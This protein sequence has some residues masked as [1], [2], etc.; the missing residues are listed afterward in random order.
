MPFIV[1]IVV[2]LFFSCTLDAS[3]IVWS[4]AG[5]MYSPGRIIFHQFERGISL[6]II[7]ALE[8]KIREKN[9]LVSMVTINNAGSYMIQDEKAHRINTLNADLLIEI[10]CYQEPISPSI[11]VY[12][13]G[14]EPFPICTTH[15]L[16]WCPLE[17]SYM[18]NFTHTQSYVQS[19]IKQLEAE[20]MELSINIQGP[21]FLPLSP[22]CGVVVPSIIIEFGLVAHD[23]WII[24]I[25]ALATAIVKESILCYKKF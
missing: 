16:F 4:A 12:H 7:N 6:Q 24:Y 1:I 2:S 20:T 19:L 17:K 13:Y 14:Y 22:L 18:I 21:F 5:D 8:K 25:D 10:H 23:S 15:S 9:P 11:T 3:L